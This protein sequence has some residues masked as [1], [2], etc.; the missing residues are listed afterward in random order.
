MKQLT[1]LFFCLL[2]A[3]GQTASQRRNFDVFVTGT[4]PG[5]PNDN[6]WTVT[7]THATA[8]VGAVRF[9]SGKVLLSSRPHWQWT[10]LFISSAWAHPG[11]YQKGTA[12][13]EWLGDTEVN[14][15]AATPTLLGNASAVT[16]EY[17]SL[18]L[19][20][21]SPG[22]HVV[23]TASKGA[24][25]FTFDTTAYLPPLPIEG[26]RFDTHISIELG[27]AMISVSFDSLISRIDFAA[28]NGT[29]VFTTDS[30]AFNGFARGVLDTSTYVSSWSAQ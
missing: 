23:G 19:T 15:L 25:R 14:L 1:H 26:V 24:E 21:A 6:G 12:L 30:T 22:I 8:H 28:T 4:A 2:A 11:H 5:K 9:Y 16:G 27:H 3:C 17:G 10:D 20:F 29:H 18:E 13:G 7:L